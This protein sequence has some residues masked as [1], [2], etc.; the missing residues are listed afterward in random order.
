MYHSTMLANN[1]RNRSSWSLCLTARLD[2]LV[3]P[4]FAY[5]ESLRLRGDLVH[6]GTYRI[7]DEYCDCT[8]LWTDGSLCCLPQTYIV[9]TPCH[10]RGLS[11]Q[12]THVYRLLV[13]IRDISSRSMNLRQ[14]AYEQARRKGISG[15]ALA[16]SKSTRPCATTSAF[17]AFAH[18]KSSLPYRRTRGQSPDLFE[19]IFSA[20]LVHWCEVS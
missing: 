15:P 17:V 14:L 12:P 4:D 7:I 20:S 2:G 19:R 1:I 3:N 11:Q 8:A 9:R 13:S 5:E 6:T 16:A 10:R 18:S